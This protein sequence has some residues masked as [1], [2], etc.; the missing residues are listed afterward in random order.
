ML[1]NFARVVHAKIERVTHPFLKFDIG[2][3]GMPLIVSPSQRDG[4]RIWLIPI[5]DL[6]CS[7]CC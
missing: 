7:K 2:L 5:Q 3:S 4:L 1:N 6:D